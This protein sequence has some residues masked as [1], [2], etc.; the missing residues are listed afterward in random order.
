MEEDFSY[1]VTGAW[2]LL[3]IYPSVSAYCEMYTGH[4]AGFTV[5]C[6][7][8]GTGRR[9][10]I[11]FIITAIEIYHSIHQLQDLPHKNSVSLDVDFATC[12]TRC[13]WPPFSACSRLDVPLLQMLEKH[14]VSLVF[15]LSEIFSNFHPDEI[16]THTQSLWPPRRHSSRTKTSMFLRFTVKMLAVYFSAYL[17]LYVYILRTDFLGVWGGSGEL[18]GSY[19][20]LFR[21][22]CYDHSNKNKEEAITSTCFSFALKQMCLNKSSAGGILQLGLQKIYQL[23][24][25]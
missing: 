11:Y 25:F 22:K 13:Y 9:R 18:S 10:H 2:V 5:P 1:V 3:S 15:C 17:F 21:I 4:T 6:P 7:S 20:F 8:E 24:P 16:K 23:E 12:M 19:S 14:H